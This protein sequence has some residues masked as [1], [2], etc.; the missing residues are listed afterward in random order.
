MMVECTKVG[1]QRIFVLVGFNIR[2]MQN[3][4]KVAGYDKLV[5]DACVEFCVRVIASSTW[6]EA[7]LGFAPK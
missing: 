5:V 4:G 7:L 6:E 1:F 3:S 2:D